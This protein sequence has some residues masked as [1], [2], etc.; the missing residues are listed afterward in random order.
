MK[1]KSVAALPAVAVTFPLLS[2]VVAGPS[3]AQG[4]YLSV[5]GALSDT[6]SDAFN[7]GTNGAGNPASSIDSTTRY[8]LSLGR[9]LS[10]AVKLELEYSVASY[11]TDPARAPGSGIRAADTFGITSDLDVD[12]LTLNA[13][14]EFRS[15]S[16]FRPF[17]KV[18]AGTTFF[19]ASA[20]LFVSSFAGDDFGGFLPT[21]FSYA[22]DGSEFAY[23]AA[24]GFAV[25]LNDALDITAEY[26][27]A[28]LGRVATEFDENGDRIQTQLETQNVQIGLRFKF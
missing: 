16:A 8:G 22:G 3:H 20:D 23:L 24:L 5:N 17:V 1:F 27:F 7:D 21:T 25:E 19:D 6:D 12:L 26:R 18:G 15:E 4:W 14:Y 11:E 28:D 9:A 10:K 2:L 13:S